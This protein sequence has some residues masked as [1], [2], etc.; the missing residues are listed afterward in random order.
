MTGASPSKLPLIILA[1]SDRKPAVLP[2]GA[3][4]HPLV[5][6]KGYDIRIGGRHLVDLLIE[7]LEASGYF[8]PI[9]LAGPASLY[10][11]RRGDVEVIDTDASL[12]ENIRTSLETV[13]AHHPGQRIAIGTCDVIP[14]EDDLRTVMAEYA[15]QP[16]LNFWFGFVCVPPERARLGVSGWKPQYLI[17]AHP[18]EKPHNVL[19]GHL[20]IV[21]PES[22]R[23]D[24]LYRCFQLAYSTRNRPI[25]QRLPVM[26][27]GVLG[28]LL[29]F[30]LGRLRAFSLPT[31]TVGVAWHAV[32]LAFDLAR[33]VITTGQLERHFHA[34]FVRSEHK[35]RYPDRRG[36]LSLVDALSLAKDI[37]TEEEARER[38][39]EL[40]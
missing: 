3:T 19:P 22:L 11:E 12:G 36:L 5:G 6:A 34:M 27:F 35:R 13:V 21:D 30:D 40:A 18:D 37:D 4:V 31:V 9:F 29:R 26:L 23:R 17:R 33:G 14:E 1:G 10:G 16:D 32:S 28:A 15:S 25:L 2:E 7:R 8:G 24:F 39:L 20:I 38:A